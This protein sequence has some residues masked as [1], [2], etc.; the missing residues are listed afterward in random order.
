MKKNAGIEKKGI[1]GLS[2]G[3]SLEILVFVFSVLIR[4][5]SLGHDNFNT[6][7]WRWKARSYDFGSGVFSGNFEATLQKYHPGV[8]L[9]WAG[10]AG[11]KI[12]NLWAS[13]KGISL[14]AGDD[15][16]VIFHLDFVQ[17]FLVVLTISLT[18]S[19]LFYALKKALN[20]RYAV[21]AVLL[22]SLE[23]FYLGLT[24][25][26][27]L[28]GMVS[29]FMLASV[30]WM[31]YYFLD[32][33]NKKRLI[34]SGV[35][36]GFALLTKTSALFL[37]PFYG[38]SS[39]M[40]LFRN[41]KYKLLLKERPVINFSHFFRLVKDFSVVFFP[42]LLVSISVFFVF[43]PAMW[44]IPF[45]VI[46]TLYAGIADIGVEGDHIQFYFGELIEDPGPSFYFVVL[47][48]RSSIYLLIGFIGALITRRKMSDN[49]RSFFDFLFIFIFFYFIQLTL[50]TKKLDRYILPAFSVI[51]LISS[52]FFIWILDRINL[53][54]A[55]NKFIAVLLFLI[56]AFYTNIY[57]HP[58]Y[59]S[60]FNP[61][62]GGLK[63]GVK[64]LEPKWLIGMEEIVNY[65]KK[66]SE[67]QGSAFSSGVSFEELVYKKFGKDLKTTMTVGFKEKY[68]T[69]IW[70]FFREFGAWAVI[71]ELKPFADR[72]KYFVYPVWDDTS[73]SES[74]M[75]LSY[76]D[77]ISLRGITLYNV[78]KNEMEGVY[79]K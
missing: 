23:P 28:E 73:N 48:L 33:K 66:L 65:F 3:L 4:I 25:M 31:H 70:P 32:I 61:M 74:G 52:L 21:L 18:T 6:D 78:Y 59:L 63:T 1:L 54:K 20:L 53:K 45:K 77:S 14:T 7:V 72:T 36:A 11:A 5:P 47:G 16:G 22:L 43:W 27:H 35:F 13:H 60:Y 29:T 62:F 49:E 39:F 58:D 10:S 40:Y 64:V 79:A 12:T 34:I 15:V 55:W 51:S 30:V 26:F 38:L 9:M 41:G 44:V 67:E 42:W 2:P 71:K 69:Q 37:V 46:Q 57:V 56:P 76:F 8:T 24:R 75:E 50:P 68:Y 17:K 19:F